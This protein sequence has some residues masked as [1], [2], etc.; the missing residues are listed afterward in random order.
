M[1]RLIATCFAFVLLSIAVAQAATL[2][3]RDFKDGKTR[4]DL[5]GEIQPGDADAIKVAIQASNERGNNP[6][7]FYRRKYPRGAEDS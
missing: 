3:S 4:L 7:E 5:D 6:S 1:L 2:K